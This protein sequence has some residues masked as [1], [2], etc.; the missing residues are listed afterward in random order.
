V[1][2]L[3][4]R[5]MVIRSVA[6]G[7][8]G[9]GAHPGCCSLSKSKT[10]DIWSGLLLHLVP[11]I[12]W[13]CTC[14]SAHAFLACT[15]RALRFTLL[16]RIRSGSW[17]HCWGCQYCRYTC[18][19]RGRTKI[20]RWSVAESLLGSDYPQ[21]T[22]L[23][24]RVKADTSH[25]GTKNVTRLLWI[26]KNVCSRRPATGPYLEP[27]EW[28]SP[29]PQIQ[30]DV[31]HVVPSAAVFATEILYVCLVALFANIKLKLL[32]CNKI[33]PLKKKRRLLYLKTQ[34][35]P[36]CKHFSSRL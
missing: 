10:A 15:E 13:R 33:N 24:L 9:T 11:N 31:Y 3:R 36:R 22:V 21:L 29:S 5:G 26:A 23:R 30:W 27:N 18:R 17:E 4:N 7:H 25:S 8:T 32:C 34:S 6:G 19:S 1:T 14:K 35:V 28:W 2:R 16:R 20:H 12:E